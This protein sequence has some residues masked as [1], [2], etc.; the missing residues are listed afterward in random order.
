MAGPFEQGEE[1]VPRDKK[2]SAEWM[3]SLTE[4][5][6]PE[7]Y[8]RE[9]LRYIGM[10]VGGIACGQLYLGGDGR[11]WYWDIFK[12]VTSTD[13]Q[14]QAWAGH[15]YR[16]PITPTDKGKNPAWPDDPVEHGFCIRWT[17]GGNSRLHRLDGTGFK[18]VT[19]R[20]EYPVGKVRYADPS[21]PLTVELEAFSPF[22]PLDGESSSNPCTVLSY[23]LKNNSNRKLEVDLFGWLENAVCRYGTRGLNLIRRNTA[24]RHGDRATVDCYMVEGAPEPARPDVLVADFERADYGGWKVE[25]TAFGTGPVLK[26]AIPT[27]QGDVGGEGQRVVNSH[28]TAPGQ[29]VAEKDSAT[30]KLTSEEFTIQRKFVSFYI[31]GGANVEQVG[32]RLVVDGKVVRRAAGHDDNKMR[33]ELFDVTE[34]QG[35]KAVIEIYDQGT[36]GWG[37]IGVDQIVQTDR[38]AATKKEEVPG[39]GSMTLSVLGSNRAIKFTANTGDPADPAAILA[40][41]GSETSVEDRPAGERLIGAV[42]SSVSIDAGKSAM[43]EFLLTWWFPYYGK[44]SGEMAAVKEP[45]MVRHYGKRHI[46]A[47]SAADYVSNH[48]RDLSGLTRLW[49]KTWYESTLPYWLLDR[50][51]IPIDCLA[52]QAMHRFGSGRWWGWEGVDCCPGTCQHV[53]HYA[54]AVGRIFPEIERDLRERVDFG[55]SWHESGAM[56][57][58]AENDRHVAHDGFCG[59][60][61]RAYREHTMSPDSAFLKRIWPRVRKSIEFIM[62]QDRDGDG[63]LEGEQMNTLDAAWYGPMGWIS[64][65]FLASLAAG[66]AMAT[67]MSD[68]AFAAKCKDRLAAGRK[69]LLEKLYDGEYFVHAPP[70]FKHTNTNRGC[71]I[72]QVMGQSLAFQAGLPRVIP[73]KESLSALKS[74]WTYN[75]TPDVGQYRSRFKAIN[76]GRWYAMPGEAGLLMCT[77]PKGGAEN[78][79]GGGN[80]NFVAYFNECMTGFEYQ[81]ASH[82]VW[83]G[84]VTEGLAIARAIHDRYHPSR[85]NPYNEVECSDHYSRAMAAYGVFTAACGF[86]YHG[87][88]GHIGF[89]PR[90]SPENFKAPFVAAEGWVTYSQ[91]VENGQMRATLEVKHGRLMVK[92]AGFRGPYNSCK[93]ILGSRGLAATARSTAD[94]TLV[95]LDS[96][97]TIQAGESLGV[98]LG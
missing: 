18:E 39:Y 45:E 36:G 89:A 63:I 81:V 24:M 28:A 75:F 65:I 13:Y 47:N 67:E 92:R 66:E 25:G 52:T 41:L 51:F 85:R 14:N 42:G 62:A 5:G 73:Q 30:G 90:I 87:P 44:V 76:G 68:L 96:A 37:N 86:E 82:M 17:D 69:S 78:A 20:G 3:R 60:I 33:K 26:S 46:S 32:L 2:L 9:Q 21:V 49:N 88:K 71:H 43:V 16:Y 59:T 10:P 74:L 97:V 50:S 91:R 6:R 4:R 19:F 11:L 72:D 61:I 54:Q 40:K 34:L 56:D 7:E 23:R 12:S 31:G 64:S 70:D 53:W 95:T 93:V 29:S 77:W 55:L 84:M 35:K 58:R 8:T 83:E 38:P 98:V 80:G 15:K 1:L 57:F 27:Y 48:I 22:V 94:A 79:S